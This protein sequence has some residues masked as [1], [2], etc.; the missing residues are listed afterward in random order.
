MARLI[1]AGLRR[2]G[3]VADVAGRGEEAVWMAES[4]EYDAIVL[5][6]RLPGIDGVETCG[7][8]RHNGV[9]TPILMLTVHDD[10]ERRGGAPGAGGGRLVPKAVLLPPLA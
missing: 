2:T 3:I 5:D 9:R 4:I 8:M 6:L 1:E 7:R 10:L